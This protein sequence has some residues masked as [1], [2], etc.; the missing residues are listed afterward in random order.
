MVY[1]KAMGWRKVVLIIVGVLVVIL[2]IILIPRKYNATGSSNVSQSQTETD[3]TTF[4]KKIFSNGNCQTT[5]STTFTA[6]PMKPE[7]LAVIMPLGMMVRGHV[8]PIDHQYFY[9]MGIGPDQSGPEKPVYSPADGFIVNVVRAP[10]QQVEKHLKS[11]DGYDLLIEHS[12]SL[13]TRLGL[14][15]G[16]TD[17]MATAIGSIERGQKKDV[18]IPVKAGQEVARV[19]G[20]S[21][22]LTTYS[23]TTPAKQWIVPSHYQEAGKQYATDAFLF[24]SPAIKAALLA[25]NPRTIEPVGGRFDYDIDGHLVGTW[26]LQGTNGY[27]ANNDQDYWKGHLVF[28]YNGFDPTAIEISMGSWPKPG[29]TERDVNQGW[30][31][32]VKANKP[33]PKD[34]TVTTGPVKYELVN[35][36]LID[37]NG[38]RWN[39]TY[40]GPVTVDRTSSQVEGVLLVE[41]VSDRLIK[42]E[43]FPGKTASQVSSFTT[44]A[45]LFER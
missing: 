14:L 4:F 9:P 28:V 18:R 3:P 21:L 29:L 20:Q 13:Y 10:E 22:D 32:A 43:K 7:D 38:Q 41:M 37:Q 36:E 40:N 34:V 19:G 33:D 16:I 30:Q 11:R 24:Y 31:F 26:F 35:F 12:C 6:T 5:G 1:T 25:K 15:S 17:E 23:A 42:A 44:N 45:Q 39:N 27:Q 8:T 2:A